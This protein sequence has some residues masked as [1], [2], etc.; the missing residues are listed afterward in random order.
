MPGDFE[1]FFR[2]NEQRIHFQIRRLGIADDWYA[3]FYSEGIV[4]LWQAYRSYQSERGQLGTYLN[5]MIRF[6]LLDLLR[7]KIRDQERM[8]QVILAEGIFLNDGNRQRKSGVPLIDDKGIPLTCN[9]EFW[10]EVRKVLSEK[11]WKWVQYFIIAD[12]TVKEIMEIEDVSASAVK[13]WGR[14][15]RKKL[16]DENV[17][18]RLEELMR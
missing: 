7:K 17:R 10:Q 14:E 11:Q 13:S 9:E 18:R 1:E 15:V 2:G 6:R 4:A 12:L 3:D 16:R 8:E 5:Y